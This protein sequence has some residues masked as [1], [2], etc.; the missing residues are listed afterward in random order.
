MKKVLITG[1]AQGLGASIAREFIKYFDVTITYN[2]NYELA[3][4]LKDELNNKYNTSF[5]IIKCDITNENDINNVFSNKY[6]VLINN[7]S[8]SMDND[9][10]EKTKEEFMRVLEV[11]LVGTFLMCKKAI[12]NGV[13][14][15]INISSTDSVD[16]YQSLN[17]DYS[18]S[19]AGVNI[20]T[21]TFA[22]TYNK[23]RVLSILP[24]W[25][26]TES[27]LLMDKDYLKSELERIGQGKL[28]DKEFVAKK[29]YE[30]YMNKDITSGEL[31]RIDEGDVNV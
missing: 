15:I 2:T 5:D 28:L 13:K 4:Y 30:I 24:N 25:I 21:K 19:K 16:T 20:L 10:L 6:D 29:I 11:N 17:I 14:D 23:V 18:T 26:N 31:I 3:S 9:I 22:L 7:A 27:V 8:L 12:K 1:G